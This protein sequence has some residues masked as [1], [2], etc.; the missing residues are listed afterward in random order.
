MRGECT[1]AG[2][3]LDHSEKAMQQLRDKKIRE[4]AQ[5]K[6]G[7]KTADLVPSFNRYANQKPMDGGVGGQKKA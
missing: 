3:R 1:N 5:A 4:L 2:C 7:P 6:F